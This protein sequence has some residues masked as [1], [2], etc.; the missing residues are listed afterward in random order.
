M[1]FFVEANLHI[2][3]LKHYR[4]YHYSSNVVIQPAAVKRTIDVVLSDDE[5]KAGP[6]TKKVRTIR[7]VSSKLTASFYEDENSNATT[8]LYKLDPGPLRVI[9]SINEKYFNVDRIEKETSD[10]QAKLSYADIE[11][12]VHK[13]RKQDRFN[14]MT[15]NSC[16][17]TPKKISRPELKLAEMQLRKQ[18][19]ETAKWSLQQQFLEEYKDYEKVIKS[20]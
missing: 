1:T 19:R 11:K 7:G 20:K 15:N 17:T 5:D 10:I 18:A 16:Y 4:L 3:K 9:A 14:A 12:Q 6:T 8:Q 13:N 2:D